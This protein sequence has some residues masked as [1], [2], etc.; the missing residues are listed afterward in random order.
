[1]TRTIALLSGACLLLLTAAPARADN[2]VPQLVPRA[3]PW[4]VETINELR[5]GPPPADGKAELAELRALAAKRTAAQLV[6]IRW[7]DTG[8]PAY[9]WNELALE[10]LVDDFVALPLAARHLAL[11]HA[12]IDDAVAAA[13]AN[14]R[15]YRRARP[16]AVDASLAT[17]LATPKSPS[18]PSDYAAAAAAAADV[19]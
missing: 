15:L 12:A 8:G 16:R 5:V 11:V 3:Q 9:R 2:G 1:M 10:T 17:A 18:Y 13:W 4:L 6:R 19:L 7:W 14:K